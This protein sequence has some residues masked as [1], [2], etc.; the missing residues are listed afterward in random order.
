[1]LWPRNLISETPSKN[2]IVRYDC[3]MIVE[4]NYLKSDRSIVALD[5][6]DELPYTI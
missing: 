3:L 6:I 1:M 2:E 5:R 4:A